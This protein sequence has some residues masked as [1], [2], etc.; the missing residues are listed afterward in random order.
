MHDRKQMKR[1]GRRKRIERHT[2]KEGKYEEEE[3]HCVAEAFTPISECIFLFVSFVHGA[4]LY[5]MPDQAGVTRRFDWF[6]QC[7]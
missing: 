6:N 2:V 1:S 5:L 4:L 7:D 3:A